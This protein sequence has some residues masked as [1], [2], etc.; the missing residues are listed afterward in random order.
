MEDKLSSSNLV[1]WETEN[2][3]NVVTMVNGRTY[4]WERARKIEE[5]EFCKTPRYDMF[6]GNETE[7]WKVGYLSSITQLL[8]GRAEI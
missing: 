3:Q 6:R 7:A 8:N 4:C 5:K 1:C 2:N